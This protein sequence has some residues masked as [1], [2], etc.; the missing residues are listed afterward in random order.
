[1]INNGKVITDSLEK[2]EALNNQ[3][4]SVFTDEDLFDLPQLDLLEYPMMP[5]ISF[6]ISGIHSLLLNLD[7]N[8]SPGP[9]SMTTIFLKKCAD[10]VSPILQVIFTQSMNS[11]T[12]PD[13]WLSANI[14]PVYKKNDRAN[15][16]NY[17]PISLT[18]ICCKVMEHI[19]YH[20]VMKHLNQHNILNRFQYGFRQGFSCE[21]QLVS[22]VEDILFALDNLYQVDLVL[23]DFCKA[24]NT[25]PHQRL[26]LK[27]Q[28][29]RVKNRNSRLDYILAYT[30]DAASCSRWNSL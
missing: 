27:L 12:L 2:A 25:I 13:D 4:Y 19:I 23:L 18:A 7:S 20:S 29:Y 1:M 14:T 16:L 10:E 6:S 3:F 26:L 28:L 17:R 30:K 8:K 11:G 22:V 24:F 15:V 21:A 9:D 5:E